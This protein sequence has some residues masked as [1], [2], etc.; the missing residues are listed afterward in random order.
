M[1]QHPVLASLQGLSHGAA[2][3]VAKN[4]TRPNVIRTVNLIKARRP[5][6]YDF[7]D[8]SAYYFEHAHCLD[9]VVESDGDVVL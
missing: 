4:L 7:A 2:T 5:S 3:R 6:S 8:Y 1:R 9:R